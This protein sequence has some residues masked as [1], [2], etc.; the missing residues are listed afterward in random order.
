MGRPRRGGLAAALLKKKKKKKKG[1]G[2]KGKN[3]HELAPGHEEEEEE[4]VRVPRLPLW[5][6]SP[7]SV[8]MLLAVWQFELDDEQKSVAA[9]KRN[10]EGE[11]DN[12]LSE[13]RDRDRHTGA[14][15]LQLTNDACRASTTLNASCARQASCWRG[16]T[17]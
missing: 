3:Q 1:D 15:L 8:F 9:S 14:A 13:F 6:H 10:L 12:V 4:E 2:H 5:P 16:F 17:R 7:A 11:E